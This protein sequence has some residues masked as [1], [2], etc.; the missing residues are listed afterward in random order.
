MDE[1]EN[2]MSEGNRKKLFNESTTERSW[3]CER[4]GAGFVD[5]LSHHLAF[6]GCLTW[7]DCIYLSSQ[8]CMKK[9]CE[10][11]RKSFELCFVGFSYSFLESTL[12]LAMI[13][14]LTLN[15]TLSEIFFFLPRADMWTFLLAE[16]LRDSPSLSGWTFSITIH[17]ITCLWH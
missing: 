17:L 9:W 4:V 1:M 8:K 6:H 14:F 15:T 5:Q 13:M 2:D 12:S 10:E 11:R 3:Q 16:L 7:W